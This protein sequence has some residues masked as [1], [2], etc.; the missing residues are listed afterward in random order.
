VFQISL[1]QM[2]ALVA[3]AAVASLSLKLAND[4]WLTLVMTFAMMAVFAAIVIAAFDRGHRQAFAVAFALI[5]FGYHYI[6]ITSSSATGQI[7]REYEGVS[8]RLPSSQL[9]YLV[10][11]KFQKTLWFDP[12]TNESFGSYDP[13]SPPPAN[14]PGQMSMQLRSF[15]SEVHYMQIGHLWFALLLG[16]VGGFIAQVF[17]LRGGQRR[18]GNKSECSS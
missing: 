6:V 14:P 18:S 2:F 3:L 4:L 1:R 15:P 8:A 13:N 17:Y 16:L 10:W 5:A 11:S 9:L 7:P 12:M